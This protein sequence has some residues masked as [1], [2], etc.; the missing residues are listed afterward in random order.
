MCEEDYIRMDTD[1][2]MTVG[3]YLFIEGFLSIVASH[4]RVLSN[5]GRVGRTDAWLVNR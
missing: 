3:N 1:R 2:E 4:Q 5:I